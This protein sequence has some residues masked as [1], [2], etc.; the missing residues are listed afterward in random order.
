MEKFSEDGFPDPGAPAAVLVLLFEEAGESR[1]LLTRRAGHLRTHTGEVS[2]PGGRLEPGET[3]EEGALREAAEEVALEPSLVEFIGR[4][5]PLGTFSSGTTITPVVG[6]LECR[7]KVTANPSEVE[8]VFDVA[9]A[10]L[11]EPQIFREERWLV[12]DRFRSRPVD[13]DGSFPVWFFELDHDTIWGATARILMEIL[14]L[15]LDV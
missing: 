12:P 14:R 3:P 2:F 8:R 15:V 4:L 7:P 10:E 13:S 6:V 5:S 9:L 1:V 11:A